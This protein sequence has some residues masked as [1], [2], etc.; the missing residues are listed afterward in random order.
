M[1]ELVSAEDGTRWEV[2]DACVIG[3]TAA[4]DIQIAN[5]KV[6]RE[7]AMIR[8]K[9][10]GY[11]I[12]DL[13][14]AN[15]CKVNGIAVRQPVRLR[16]G[17]VIRIGGVHLTFYEST[18]VVEPQ[19]EEDAMATLFQVEEVPMAIL[20]ADLKGYTPLSEKLS[21]AE[22]ADLLAPWYTECE[23]IIRDAGG[24]LDKFIGDCVFA[25]WRRP[26]RGVCE[27]ALVAGQRLL[28]SPTKLS[29]AQQ[30]L[31]D[32][33]GIELECG[34]GLHWGRAAVGA[35]SRGNQTALGGAIN[36][37][38]RVESL[39]RKLGTSL[40]ATRAF[41]EL[42]EHELNAHFRSCGEHELKGCSLPVEVFALR[43]DTESSGEG[44]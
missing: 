15:G 5:P 18:A 10:D 8:K 27:R 16:S 21:E 9:A 19:P 11:S 12:Y 1:A 41:V 40:V 25:Y 28:N 13:D 29:D 30:Q 44:D 42:W 36:I 33:Q 3:R 17:D 43:E 4:A 26:D 37:A 20:V 14:S 7:H 38:F 23:E 22:L 39:T 24:E 2:E 31:I 32:E 35:M 34:V 6:S